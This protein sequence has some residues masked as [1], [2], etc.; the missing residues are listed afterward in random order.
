MTAGLAEA[1]ASYYLTTT[2]PLGRELSFHVDY[3]L[4]S[5]YIFIC[6]RDGFNHIS[7]LVVLKISN[8]IQTVQYRGIP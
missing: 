7:L 8:L 1:H 5:P 4:G 3:K 6:Y 2:T